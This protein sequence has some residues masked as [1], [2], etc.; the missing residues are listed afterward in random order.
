MSFFQ[1]MYYDNSNVIYLY[2]YK[3][4]YIFL[5]MMKIFKYMIE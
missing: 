5:T 3:N 4:L 2:T 1:L